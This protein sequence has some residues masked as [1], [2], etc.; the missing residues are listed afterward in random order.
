MW[1]SYTFGTLPDKYGI[2]ELTNSSQVFSPAGLHIKL[3][4]LLA[5]ALDASCYTF[6]N[7]QVW[8]SNA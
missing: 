7:G 5:A 2:P 1:K 4:K 3:G 6:D 8:G